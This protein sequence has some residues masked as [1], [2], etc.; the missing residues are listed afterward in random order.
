MYNF[1]S[2]KKGGGLIKRTFSTEKKTSENTRRL[3]LFLSCFQMFGSSTFSIG[4]NLF[5]KLLHRAK[6]KNQLVRSYTAGRFPRSPTTYMAPWALFVAVWLALVA[7]AASEPLGHNPKSGRLGKAIARSVRKS[8]LEDDD[9][10]K[11]KE[12][13]LSM[14]VDGE[15]DGKCYKSN[16]CTRY[17]MQRNG[18]KRCYE[19]R[20]HCLK[21]DDCPAKYHCMQGVD[22]HR[23]QCELKTFSVLSFAKRMLSKILS[24]FDLDSVEDEPTPGETLRFPTIEDFANQPEPQEDLA[25]EPFMHELKGSESDGQSSKPNSFMELMVKMGVSPEKSFL[26]TC[27]AVASSWDSWGCSNPKVRDQYLSKRLERAT[28]T[29]THVLIKSSKGETLAGDYLTKAYLKKCTARANDFLQKGFGFKLKAKVLYLENDEL[30]EHDGGYNATFGK[31]RV[32]SFNA[33]PEMEGAEFGGTYPRKSIYFMWRRFPNLGSKGKIIGMS[34]F[35]GKRNYEGVIDMNSFVKRASWQCAWTLAHE[36]GHTLGLFHSHRTIEQMAYL[37][38]ENKCSCG[39]FGQGEVTS[40]RGDFCGDTLPEPKML[41]TASYLKRQIKKFK[42]NK[43]KW[44]KKIPAKELQAD[45]EAYFQY[46]KIVRHVRKRL[47]GYLNWWLTKSKFV[48]AMTCGDMSLKYSFGKEE[49]GFNLMSY[50]K[51]GQVISKHQRARA[52]CFADRTPGLQKIFGKLLEDESLK[53]E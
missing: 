45:F 34:S 14:S 40:W 50:G 5:Y 18:K 27:S 1:K 48:K 8:C 20:R 52:L 31:E 16:S 29:A 35:P 28:I 25:E 4:F 2:W 49:V 9:C 43:C 19:I 13:F 24:I 42:K 15:R 11:G 22:F 30:F 41:K 7:V 6:K 12:C 39:E 10:K 21:N 46:G 26:E 32:R 38:S 17:S 33:I 47:K 37:E 51:F 3:C 36:V 23:G 44:C 53:K